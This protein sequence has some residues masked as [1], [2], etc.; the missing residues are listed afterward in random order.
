MRSSV[1]LVIVWDAR[2]AAGALRVIC[3]T[4]N[5]RTLGQARLRIH[6]DEPRVV[7]RGSQQLAAVAG[8]V[9][10]D[11]DGQPVAVLEAC[12]PLRR[13]LL[14]NDVDVRVASIL[15]MLGFKWQ[16]IHPTTHMPRPHRR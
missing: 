10:A 14:R 6:H 1:T 3:L 4:S 11:A 13:H 15:R 5:Q 8:H 7:Q 16:N 9:D 12:L 2:N